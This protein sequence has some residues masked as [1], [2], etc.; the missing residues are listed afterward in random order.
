MFTQ[1]QYEQLKKSTQPK[2]EFKKRRGRSNSEATQV[3]KSVEKALTGQPR[4]KKPRSGFSSKEIR[5]SGPQVQWVNGAY[6]AVPVIAKRERTDRG[7]YAGV[8]RQR[9]TDLKNRRYSIGSNQ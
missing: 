2:I 1:E 8:R 3:P 4:P 5:A 9:Q 6:D 7:E